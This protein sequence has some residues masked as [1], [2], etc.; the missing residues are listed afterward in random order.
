MKL[1]KNGRNIPQFSSLNA[2]HE[3]DA[4]RDAKWS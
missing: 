4:M 1:G 2:Y 3:D